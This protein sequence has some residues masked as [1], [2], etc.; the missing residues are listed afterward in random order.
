M[1]L[2]DKVAAVDGA[3]GIGEQVTP[4][5]LPTRL[6]RAWRDASWIIR[7]PV[8][9]LAGVA[10]IVA[11]CWIVFGF[12]SLGLDATATFAAVVGITLT[13]GLGIGLMTLIFYSDRSGRDD[14]ARGDIRER[15][16]H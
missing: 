7:F 4:L 11:L 16:G 15:N 12:G 8:T 9:A 1:R 14:I 6:I 3:S 2:E 5:A 10:A 13:V